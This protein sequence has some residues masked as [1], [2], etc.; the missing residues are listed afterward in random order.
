MF[1]SGV[2]WEEALISSVGPFPWCKYS[3]S[4]QHQAPGMTSWP[5]SWEETQVCLPTICIN[6]CM[7]CMCYSWISYCYKAFMG[8]PD[9][10]DSKES[11]CNARDLGLIPGL[12][13]SPGEGNGYPRQ[14]S[15]LADSMNW[16]AWQ[17]TVRGLQSQTWLSN[18]TAH[19]QHTAFVPY[20]HSEHH[21]KIMDD[22]K[23]WWHIRKRWVLRVYF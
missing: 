17:A 1:S 16:G 19:T 15:C 4:R 10:S 12:G 23:M 21:L 20:R 11:A 8:F 18:S 14:Y 9:G 22:S 2:G 13:R 5:W 7:T 3:H 6:T